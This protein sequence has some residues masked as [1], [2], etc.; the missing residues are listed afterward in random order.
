MSV[1]D[2]FVHHTEQVIRKQNF[3]FCKGGLFSP[4]SSLLSHRTILFIMD[5]N[6][7]DFPWGKTIFPDK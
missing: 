1:V 3:V 5:E 6:I 2:H 4:W 7:I